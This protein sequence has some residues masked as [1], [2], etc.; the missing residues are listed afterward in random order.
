MLPMS[1]PVEDYQWWPPHYYNVIRMILYGMKWYE[2]VCNV[3]EVV[4]DDVLEMGGFKWR[5][6][7]EGGDRSTRSYEKSLF[8]ISYV[9][10]C[11]WM[12]I[13]LIS[14]AT[15][16]SVHVRNEWLR[17]RG[18]KN[19]FNIVYPNEIRSTAPP[20]PPSL[21]V[22]PTTTPP[23]YLLRLHLHTTTAN[24][25]YRILSIL[26]WSTILLHHDR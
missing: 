20:P 17:S 2:I 3:V 23:L 22:R 5:K 7:Q 19:K 15:F 21:V 1:S 9:G 26:L 14:H 10:G 25:H 8:H 18:D 13:F 6:K 24:C 12:C 11:R 4:T 16:T